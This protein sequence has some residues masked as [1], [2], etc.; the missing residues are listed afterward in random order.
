M[1]KKLLLVRH[2]EVG[3]EYLDR[4]IGSTDISMSPH[5]RE[6]IKAAQPLLQSS[7]PDVCISSTMKRCRETAAILTEGSGMELVFDPDLREI[8]FGR[9]EGMTFEEILKGFPNDIDR[10]I[11]FRPEF[12]FPGGEKI[13]DFQARIQGVAGR[14]AANSAD[15]ILVCTHGGVIRLLICHFLGLPPWQYVLFKVQRASLTTIELFGE[16]GMLSGLNQC[17]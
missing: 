8:D 12:T 7:T 15:T 1:A 4:Y 3:K 6:Q 2:G 17:V 14:L 16:S 10:W 5:G 9:W 11:E 13:G